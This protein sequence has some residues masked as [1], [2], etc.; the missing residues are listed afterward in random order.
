[1]YLFWPDFKVTELDQDQD[2]Q[3]NSEKIDQLNKEIA[4]LQ[5][6]IGA[7]EK[8]PDVV[9]KFEELSV[10]VVDAWLENPKAQQLDP[11]L[12]TKLQMAD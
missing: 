6:E 5:G 7:I 10:A 12:Y 11:P 9:A 1:M 2:T 8:D 3:D 4:I